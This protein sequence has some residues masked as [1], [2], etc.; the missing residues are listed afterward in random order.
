MKLYHAGASPY[1]RK[2]MI[3]AHEAGLADKI[4]TVSVTVSPT[5][6]E[7]TLAKDNPLM[8]IPCLVTRDG[9]SLYDSGVIT[10]YLDSINRRR[11]LI[12]K[13]KKRWHVKTIEALAD[14]VTDAG[15]L[16]RYETALRPNEKQW[17]DWVAG[18]RRK[19]DQGLDVLEMAAKKWGRQPD[20]G[21][22]ATAAA[23]G[24]LNLR[25]PC[26]DPLA[27]RPAL[28]AWYKRFC[29]RPSMKATEPPPPA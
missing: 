19:V 20:L 22:I 28:T 15:V 11:K 23:I 17:P 24:W 9:A 18:Q 21:Q 3:L 1:V 26:G 4:K 5:K 29:E 27:G 16:V 10:D 13:G 2:V 12:P 25:K 14:G 8:K 6:G 7:Q